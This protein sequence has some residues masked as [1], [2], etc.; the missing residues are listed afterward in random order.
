MTN[1][2][3]KQHPKTTTISRRL[4]NRADQNLT[5]QP[6]EISQLRNVPPRRVAA[7]PTLDYD[8][9]TYQN[10]QSQHTPLDWEAGT[11]AR[12]RSH[13]LLTRTGAE[14]STDVSE[15]QHLHS[16]PDYAIQNSPGELITGRESLASRA[17]SPVPASASGFGSSSLPLVSDSHNFDLPF[18]TAHEAPLS[19]YIELQDMR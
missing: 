12:S 10:P 4:R 15:T 18:A 6:A 19:P 7:Q 8:P 5:V 14:T 11:L 9:S 17:Y 3:L 13:S 2:S 16:R 1:R